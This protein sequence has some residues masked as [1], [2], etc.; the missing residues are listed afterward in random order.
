MGTG[1]SA[2]FLEYAKFA[3]Q[4]SPTR[5]SMSMHTPNDGLLP[6]VNTKSLLLKDSTVN[7]NK[8]NSK[9]TQARL[10]KQQNQQH[11]QNQDN[12]K[13]QYIFVVGT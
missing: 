2:E 3:Q 5:I 1:P 8:L 11:G 4:N 12:E 9:Y 7:L 10:A 13:A 6:F